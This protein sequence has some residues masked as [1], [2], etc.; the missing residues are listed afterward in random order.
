[1]HKVCRYIMLWYTY[2]LS[3]EVLGVLWYLV[4]YH[5]HMYNNSK[6]VLVSY[7]TVEHTQYHV[8]PLDNRAKNVRGEQFHPS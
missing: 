6:A 7:D 2:A 4:H 1:M 3:H 8:T 5:T